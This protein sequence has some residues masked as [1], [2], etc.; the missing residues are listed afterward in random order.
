MS[1]IYRPGTTW[2]LHVSATATVDLSPRVLEWDVA[3]GSL[4]DSESGRWSLQTARGILVLDNADGRLHTGADDALI[5]AAQ[6][7]L[8]LPVTCKVGD[9]TL[10]Q[11]LAVVRGS[12]PVSGDDVVTWQLRG[13][14]W[15]AI[16]SLV[17]WRQ[18]SDDDSLTTPAA[19]GRGILTAAGPG[20]SHVSPASAWPTG[21]RLRDVT[22]N[23]TLGQ[24]WNRLAHACGG[25]PFEDR[26]G[27]LGVSALQGITEDRQ[28]LWPVGA[29]ALRDGSH[30]ES[31]GA[32]S[33]W[34]LDVQQKNMV[35]GAAKTLGTT[36]PQ[37][38]TRMDS[39]R[40]DYPSG[41]AGV[42]WSEPQPTE[43]QGWTVVWWEARPAPDSEPA[44]VLRVLLRKDVSAARP[45]GA[46]FIGKEW[47]AD[48]DQPV[49]VTS[50]AQ[51][52]GGT[53]P[54][55]ARVQT[56]PPWMNPAGT[57]WSYDAYTK[58]VAWLNEPKAQATL[59][60]PL[61]Q[62]SQ[63]FRL[64]T[65]TTDRQGLLVPG[66]VARYS[67]LPALGD[68]DMITGLVA[69]AGRNDAGH[70]HPPVAEITGWTAS[71]DGIETGIPLPDT[72]PPPFDIPDP[73]VTD[74]SP[75]T[76]PAGP[77]IGSGS[78]TGAGLY[79]I[80][81]GA[82]GD[83][84][85]RVSFTDGTA[86][87]LDK[88]SSSGPVGLF[89]IGT[90]LYAIVQSGRFDTFAEVSLADGSLTHLT[91]RHLAGN[92]RSHWATIGDTTYGLMRASRSAPY[93]LVTLDTSDGSVAT[94]GVRPASSMT[95][96]AAVGTKLYTIQNGQVSV[97][98]TAD[99]SV[100][101]LGPSGF[102]SI[103]QLASAGGK[104]YA[105]AAPA[106]GAGG[107]VEV[108]LVDGSAQ[109]LGTTGAYSAIF[110]TNLGDDIYIV[111]DTRTPNEVAQVSLADGSARHLGTPD[112]S[113]SLWYLTGLGVPIDPA[114]AIL[115][116]TLSVDGY[117]LSPHFEAE[118]GNYEIFVP[119]AA[120]GVLTIRATVADPTTATVVGIG[121]RGFQTGTSA[122]DFLIN[123]RS[124]STG[125][126]ATYRIT[127]TRV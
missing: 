2:T 96:L 4:Y 35:L 36:T 72:Y 122:E 93:Q 91:T 103:T 123:V 28:T 115:L 83:P 90:K 64:Q 98:S 49:I 44:D 46:K 73:P 45:S 62:P 79:V 14:L 20:G 26:T 97:V 88:F 17:G 5:T 43:A 25:I 52:I 22:I 74:H 76:P 113:S 107:V 101:P 19:I 41:V 29:I 124:R 118:I 71:G 7:A 127:V 99:G 8:P 75:E 39:F 60:Y 30:I 12:V 125:I 81:L 33:V 100:T 116:A 21:L 85:A 55:Q 68:I 70:A 106:D 6:T 42:E 92:F 63:R 78:G 89:G 50:V 69:L 11:G 27:K 120:H 111:D 110:M 102:H 23:E 67:G 126:R 16:R 109:T 77:T 24:A 18:T 95:W 1:W 9:E 13:R 84:I 121:E 59:R 38:I 61:W 58:Y 108:S 32:A 37:G 112:D 48:A 82:D 65:N 54:E 105:Y 56:T 57:G 15:Q 80:D 53:F 66:S 119:A 94:V 51:E 104:L 31:E 47:T 3:F 87:P 114:D 34:S 86:I 40:Y 117:A 10:W